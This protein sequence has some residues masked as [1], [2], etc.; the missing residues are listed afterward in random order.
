ML[1]AQGDI[2]AAAAILQRE[3]P[4]LKEQLRGDPQLRERWIAP[5][6]VPTPV[7]TINRE[8]PKVTSVGIDLVDDIPEK[9]IQLAD[10]VGKQDDRFRRLD[11]EGMGVTDPKTLTLMRGFEKFAGGQILQTIDA[12]HGGMLH[13]FAAVSARLKFIEEQICLLEKKCEGGKEISNDDSMKL[14]FL[15]KMFKDLGDQKIKINDTAAR[16]AYVRLQIIDRARKLQGAGN[17]M[18]RKGGW[19]TAKPVPESAKGNNGPRK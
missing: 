3:V 19:R 9:D 2:P 1:A 10:Q 14:T 18:R 11:W 15:M 13:T 17:K 6:K 7:E 12:T 8:P 5:V 4:S 16:A